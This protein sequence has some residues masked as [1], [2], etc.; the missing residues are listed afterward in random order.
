MGANHSFLLCG[1]KSG[2]KIEPNFLYSGK[3]NKYVG[4]IAGILSASRYKTS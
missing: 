1:G 3:S 4:L 2:Q